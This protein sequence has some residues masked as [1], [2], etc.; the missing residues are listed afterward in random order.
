MSRADPA[1]RGDA[2]RQDRRQGGVLDRG[3]PGL[4]GPDRRDRRRVPRVPA[5]RGGAG[6]GRGRPRRRRGRRRRGAAVAAG[7]G[8]AG[9]QGRVHHHRHADHLRVEDPRGLALAVR[10][11]GDRAAARRGH[12]DPRQDQHGR[13]RD[14]LVDRELRVRP[15]PQPVGR[16]P[17]ARRLG[18]RQRGRAGRVPG[19]AGHR[20]RHRRFDPPARGADRDRRRQAHLRHGV[21][22]R[23]DRLRVVAGPGRP[24]RAHRARHRAAAPGD[25]RARPAGLDV[26]RRRGARRRRRGA[27][28][29]RRRPAAA[30]G[31][32]W[33]SSC[34]AA[35]ATSRG[36]GVVQRRRR[37]AHRAGRRGHRGRLPALRLLDGRLLPDPAVG[38]VDATW[39]ASTR[40]ATACGSATTA[41][42]APR[43]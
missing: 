20:L 13:V 24:V 8:P 1:G 14:G 11:D 40:C 29:R 3:H 35:R 10:R 30:C 25:R 42:T 18:R 41:R 17:G 21:A 38:G 33:S 26:G 22:V 28:G 39:P 31:S 7:R 6:A 43:R 34:T 36:A 27:G 37:A 19:A 4:P 23:A 12:P 16:R 2:G 9:A 5:R 15:D 32:A